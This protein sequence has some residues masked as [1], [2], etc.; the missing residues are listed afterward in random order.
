MV[1]HGVPWSVACNARLDLGYS[2]QIYCLF[3]IK[4]IQNV[5]FNSANQNTRLQF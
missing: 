4:F 1:W 5:F 2:D 3:F